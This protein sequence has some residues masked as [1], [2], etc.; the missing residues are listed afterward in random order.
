MS[1]P[2]PKMAKVKLTGTK[3]VEKALHRL[4]TKESSA[5]IANKIRSEI[6]QVMVTMNLFNQKVKKLAVENARVTPKAIKAEDRAEFELSA[7]AVQNNIKAIQGM[8]K[9][10]ADSLTLVSKKTT[11][12]NP[13][14]I[15]KIYESQIQPLLLKAQNLLAAQNPL[16]NA[17][18]E[19]NLNTPRQRR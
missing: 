19:N 5:E 16:N 10:L 12:G 4:S 2:D 11:E 9:A 8:Q 14:A 7:R 1:K 13:E 15:H 17:A 6:E 18:V 3:N